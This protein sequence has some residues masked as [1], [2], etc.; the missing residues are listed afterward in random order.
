MGKDMLKKYKTIILK[1]LNGYR[2]ANELIAEER[3]NRLTQM[4]TEDSFREYDYL[5]KL[6]ATTD[7]RGLDRLENIKISFLIKRREI[8]KRI[9]K[10]QGK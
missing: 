1:S 6:Y 5:C 2:K 4:T 8:F 3:K 7:K 9:R 10:V